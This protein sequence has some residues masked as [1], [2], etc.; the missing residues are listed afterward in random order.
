MWMDE[1]LAALY[2]VSMLT[3]G[4][5]VGVDNWRRRVLQEV[6]T[7]RP[8]VGALVRMTSGAFANEPKDF[9]LERQAANHAMARYLMLYLQERGTLAPL[10]RAFRDRDVDRLAGD[11]GDEAVRL[12]EAVVGLPVADLDRD[13]ERWFRAGPLPAPEGTLVDKTPPPQPE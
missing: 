8:S 1:G 10:Y 11:P 12:V 5:I 6:W 3:P 4:G 2:E 7:H 13:F 9:E